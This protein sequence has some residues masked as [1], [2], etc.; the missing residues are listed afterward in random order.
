MFSN[1]THG[2]CGELSAAA[3]LVAATP[4]ESQSEDAQENM[5]SS[6]RAS[7]GFWKVSISAAQLAPEDILAK[8]HDSL[9]RNS[10]GHMWWPSRDPYQKPILRNFLLNPD[11]IAEVDMVFV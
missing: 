5:A 4:R 10:S 7:H 3:E 8:V 2:W 6:D 11:A 1:A 9:E